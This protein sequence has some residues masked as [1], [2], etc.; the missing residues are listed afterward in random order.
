MPEGRLLQD[1]PL[2]RSRMTLCEVMMP[3]QPIAFG[4]HDDHSEV[5]F[6]ASLCELDAPDVLMSSL[7]LVGFRCVHSV[8]KGAHRVRTEC[9]CACTFS[10]VHRWLFRPQEAL[11]QQ[12]QVTH[13]RFR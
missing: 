4:V 7:R 3:C 1:A 8:C 6:Y 10:D 11:M 12:A 13:L 5:C 9:M 2:Y